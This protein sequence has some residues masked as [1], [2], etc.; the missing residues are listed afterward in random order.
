MCEEKWSFNNY[1]VLMEI[2]CGEFIGFGLI[3]R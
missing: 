2:L 1:N 3:V